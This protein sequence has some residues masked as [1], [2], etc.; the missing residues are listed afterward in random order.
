MSL[1]DDL[2]LLDAPFA[3][4]A[5]LRSSKK[6]TFSFSASGQSRPLQMGGPWMVCQT[7]PS[8]AGGRWPDLCTRLSERGLLLECPVNALEKL[9]VASIP[10]RLFR[11]HVGTTLM[12]EELQS[13][14][15]VEITCQL[16]ETSIWGWPPEIGSIEQMAQWL[17][18]VK[19]VIGRNTPLGLGVNVGIDDQAIEAII[20]WP[21]DFITLYASDVIEFLVD[22]LGRLRKKLSLLKPQL[23][24]L[25]RTD[26]KRIDDLLKII[27]LGGSAVTVD[28]YLSELWQQPSISAMGGFLTTH[29]PS[30]STGKNSCQVSGLFEKLHNGLLD[31]MERTR[32]STPTELNASLRA[33]TPTAARLAGIP[34][35]GE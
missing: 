24:I 30:S 16:P 26:V 18:A 27:A 12:L 10:R 17:D 9:P 34:M 7:S 13:A 35:I 23:P 19:H 6:T 11:Q 8:R 20:A 21:I 28:G 3:P 31:A 15:V 25:V 22:S 1:L 33:L 4:I 14:D 5:P 2:L 32:S 29:V